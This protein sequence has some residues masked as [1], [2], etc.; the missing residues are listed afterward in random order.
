LAGARRSANPRFLYE[1]VK[2]SRAVAQ[3]VSEQIPFLRANTFNKCGEIL[4]R[5][6]QANGA[7]GVL[8]E[9]GTY[10]QQAWVAS[11]P[12][13]AELPVVMNSLGI[14]LRVRARLDG[15]PEELQAALDLFVRA[16]SGAQ[17]RGDTRNHRSFLSNVGNAELDHYAFTGDI[18]KINDAVEH[19]N[20]ALSLY[21]DTEEDRFEQ[22][23]VQTALG[24]ALL[25]RLHFQ[26]ADPSKDLY[27][28]LSALRAAAKNAAELPDEPAFLANLARGL[29]DAHYLT[30]D[31][32]FMAEAAE[33]ATRALGGS[34]DLAVLGPTLRSALADTLISR[35]QVRQDTADL[36]EVVD[37]LRHVFLRFLK[38]AL[39]D[40]RY[41]IAW[42][43]RLP[44]A[45]RAR[46]RGVRIGRMPRVRTAC[47]AISPP[48]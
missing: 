32:K 8:A 2:L 40:H 37:Q 1:F 26:S 33:I 31:E 30:G 29:D 13:S 19:Y 28:A 18:A 46:L 3:L 22:R 11:H 25:L 12:S 42:R 23:A 6:Y 21:E 5:L 48:T 47:A 36:D 14:V 35:Y 16:V 38:P 7:V 44:C 24:N 43:G 45:A 27:D 39:N 9:A 20:E 34:R 17:S 41:S 4:Y 15:H 10:F